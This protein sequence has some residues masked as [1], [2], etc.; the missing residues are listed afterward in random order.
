MSKQRIKLP[1]AQ[2]MERT[3]EDQDY[4]CRGCGKTVSNQEGVETCQSCER[5]EDTDGNGN[6]G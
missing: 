3:N 1:T 5:E 6:D 4:I 2:E